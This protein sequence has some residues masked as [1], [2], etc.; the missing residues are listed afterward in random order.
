MRIA[1]EILRTIAPEETTMA[2]PL[3]P[4]ELWQIIEPLLPQRPPRPKGGRPPVEDRKALTGIFFVLKTGIDWEELP[5]EMGCGCGMTCW[6]R[7]RDWQADGTWHKIHRVLLDRLNAADKL[8]WSRAIIDSSSVRAAYGGEGTGPSPV[9][10][11]KPGTK[12]HVLTEAQGIP[13]TAAA[14]P[15]NVPDING[16]VPLFNAIPPVK[17]KPG[18]PRRRPDRMQGDRGYDSEPHRQGLREL[19]VEPV[20]AERG[21]ENGSGL[22]VTRWV[23]ERTL[24]WLHQNRRLRIRYERRDDIHDAFLTIGCIKICASFLFAGF[25]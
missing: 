11:G 13:L 18:R 25:C 21:T 24:S 10:R 2:K 6:R 12:H 1:E 5:Q 17:G 19:G 15:A 20:L 9:D 8:D 7:L 23:V 16:L 14:T 4:E 3:L 22:G